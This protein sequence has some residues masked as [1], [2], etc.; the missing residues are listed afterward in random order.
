MNIHTNVYVC[1]LYFS[2]F[3]I[4]IAYAPPAKTKQKTKYTRRIKSKAKHEIFISLGDS[5]TTKHD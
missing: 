5:H 4:K 2:V 3:D 1:I